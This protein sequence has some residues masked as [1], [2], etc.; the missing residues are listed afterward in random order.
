[1]GKETDH[2]LQTTNDFVNVQP[3]PLQNNE[4]GSIKPEAAELSPMKDDPVIVAADD[5]EHTV[6]VNLQN[7]RI[8]TSQCYINKPLSWDDLPHFLQS[9]IPSDLEYSYIIEKCN[10]LPAEE[11]SGAT[12]T[13]TATIRINL[14][15]ENESKVWIDKMCKHSKCTYRITRTYKSS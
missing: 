7:D 15:D 14:N 8:K 11:F 5:N 6:T 1:V 3:K 13:F 10:E 4:P 2:K 12:N 9:V